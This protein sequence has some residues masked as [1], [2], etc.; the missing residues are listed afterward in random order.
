[1]GTYELLIIA[2]RIEALTRPLIAARRRLEAH[3]ILSNAF[4]ALRGGARRRVGLDPFDLEALTTAGVDLRGPLLIATEA[5][6]GPRAYAAAL[7]LL[8]PQGAE[9]L[10]AH[11]GLQISHERLQGAPILKS[12]RGLGHVKGRQLLWASDA[13]GL[14][15]LLSPGAPTT[16]LARCPLAPGQA[17]L[18]ALW[19]PPPGD[20]GPLKSACLTVRLDPDR[21]RLEARLDL[22]LPLPAVPGEALALAPELG[23]PLIAYLGLSLGPLTR[24][25]SGLSPDLERALAGL[26]GRLALGARPNGALA[27]ALG[28]PKLSEADLDALP[29]SPKVQIEVINKRRRLSVVDPPPELAPEHRAATLWLERG[30]LRLET[31]AA[32]PKETKGDL[33]Q[34]SHLSAGL[35]EGAAVAAY[36]RFTGRPDDG[37]RL[38]DALA[39]PAFE[40]GLSRQELRALASA[41]S[42]IHAHLGELG[43][44]LRLRGDHAH[45]ILE[46]ITL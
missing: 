25:L 7:P 2:P 17:D 42:F 19:R 1:M 37:R 23:G 11:A 30:L 26:D 32:R 16:R 6:P 39:G 43:L 45:L 20:L 24:T 3:P 22:R 14:S 27:M 21:V 46:I 41:L 12:A 31:G 34:G 44:S 4:E 28:A 13:D 5:R 9:A 40:L 36:L 35:F 18:Y 10:L 15:A 33:R 8:T 29:S 38:Y